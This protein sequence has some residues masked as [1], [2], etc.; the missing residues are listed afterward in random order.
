MPLV[1]TT[2][3]EFSYTLTDADLSSGKI[4]I[5]DAFFE[6]GVRYDV[7]FSGSQYHLIDQTTIVDA[8]RFIS[9]DAFFY[10]GSV[11]LINV[12]EFEAGIL[13]FYKFVPTT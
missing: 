4:E 11:A 5:T 6:L 8:W 2:I 1:V 3:T 12:D 9:D 7:Y 13:Y 10:S